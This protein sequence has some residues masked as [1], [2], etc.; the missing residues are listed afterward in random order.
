MHC[1]SSLAAF[2]LMATTWP[3]SRCLVIGGAGNLGSHIV[4]Q[5]M[6]KKAGYVATFDRIPYKGDQKGVKSFEG[7][8]CD[9]NQLMPALEGIGVVFHTASIIDIRPV[10]SPNLYKINV[11]GA[12]CVIECCQAA[13]VGIL[14]YTSS[15]EVVGGPDDKTGKFTDF[16]NAD[17]TLPIP[18]RHCLPY[19]TTKAAAE[20]MAIAANSGKL[21]TCALRPGYIVGPGCIGMRM[22][23][24]KAVDRSG[25][26]VSAELQ[27][28]L[29]CTHVRNG[30]VGHVLAAEKLMAKDP[31]VLGKAF[32]L[33][34]F[35]ANVDQLSRLAFKGTGMIC[36]SM[37]LPV[38]FALAWSLHHIY[39][40][41][42]YA[43][44]FFGKH[45]E[46]PGSIVDHNAAGMAWRNHCFS[47][48]RAR[49]VLGYDASKISLVS[50]QESIKQCNLWSIKYY[51]ELLERKAKAKNKGQ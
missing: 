38:A 22:D 13:G 24:E 16:L 10:P 46:I 23:M 5:L 51:K 19:A 33:T 29:S 11:E 18:K 7:D 15:I 40:F 49:E 48:R 25:Y 42:F 12:K 37:P 44:K 36:K 45:L 50:E 2:D 4:E 6:A 20:K 32:F 39:R 43:F 26:H 14:V 21:R 31:N 27:T 35:D 9:K 17:E 3:Q 8:I 1:D 30:A 41:M 28:K 47:N 34:D